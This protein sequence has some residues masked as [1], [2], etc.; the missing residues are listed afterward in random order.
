MNSPEQNPV[1]DLAAAAQAI[2]AN[3][4][5]SF[6]LDDGFVVEIH[7]ATMKHIPAV[8]SFFQALMGRMD[9]GQLAALI[10][11]I[12]TKQQ[13]AVKAGKN[14]LAVDMKELANEALTAGSN[15]TA[16][17]VG[18]SIETA[19]LILNLTAAV[20]E[21]LPKVIPVFTNISVDRYED[22]TMDEAALIAGGVF[23][24]NYR[25][26]MQSLRPVL[27]SFL[28]GVMRKQTSEKPN[29]AKTAIKRIARK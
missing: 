16:N 26:F 8:M 25:F 24:V 15:D 19:S 23:I 4:V 12:V 13:E 7:P 2:F 20:L 28:A 5:N 3:G 6:A 10:D 18:S 11:R 21:E 9:Q 29:T 17:L 1:S 14:P 27:M 22:M